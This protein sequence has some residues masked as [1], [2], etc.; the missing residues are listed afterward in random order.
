MFRRDPPC[1]KCNRT[2]PCG[3]T[4]CPAC[5]VALDLSGT[6]RRSSPEVAIFETGDRTSA[7]IVVSLL[8]AHEIPCMLRGNGD[9]VHLGF[10]GTGSWRVVVQ[11][12]DEAQAQAILDA[13]IGQGEAEG[14]DEEESRCQ[15]S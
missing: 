1:P 4:V 15:G 8:R 10:G 3:T 7:D 12:A 9:G 14:R 2:Y 5:H 11:A 6:T 13:E